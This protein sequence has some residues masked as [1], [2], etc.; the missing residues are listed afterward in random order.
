MSDME[1]RHLR[2]LMTW[3][4]FGLLVL[5]GVAVVTSLVLFATRTPGT[6]GARF[7]FF[8]FGWFGAIFLFFGFFW[9]LRW[10]FWPWRWHGR[11]YWRYR[12][13]ALYILRERYARGEISKEQYDQMMRDL[14]QHT[15]A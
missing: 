11:P 2:R 12:D 13:D 5:V 6:V 15:E 9:V 7:F 14:Q 4:F 1:F 8:P 3:G 10:F